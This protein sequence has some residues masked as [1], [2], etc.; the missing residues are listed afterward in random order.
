MKTTALLICFF[1][2]VSSLPATAQG[3]VMTDEEL[4]R[5]VCNHVEQAE[6]TKTAIAKAYSETK[7][8]IDQHQKDTLKSLSSGKLD[9]LE[10]CS[11][12]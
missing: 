12:I 11:D 1:S 2:L 8:I 4:S 5:V 6:D 3:L 9:V 7:N 10:Y